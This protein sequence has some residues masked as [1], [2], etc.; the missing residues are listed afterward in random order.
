LSHEVNTSDLLW[1]L[2]WNN[3]APAVYRL[4]DETYAKLL[5]M[6]DG[7]P[8]SDDLR[9][10]MLG[11]Y[12]DPDRGFATK[13]NPEAWQKALSELD[14]LKAVPTTDVLDR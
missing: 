8:I 9:R 5:D 10:D 4:S 13:K 6:T 2:L 3:E 14:R 7:K 1:S 12:A 11:Y